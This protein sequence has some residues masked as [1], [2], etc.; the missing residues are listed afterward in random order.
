MICPLPRAREMS[1]SETRGRRDIA[2]QGGGDGLRRGDGG[3]GH[4]AAGG[5]LARTGG[6]PH[7]AASRGGTSTSATSNRTRQRRSVRGCRVAATRW[8]PAWLALSPDARQTLI[9]VLDNATKRPLYAQLWRAE[10]LH[11]VLTAV[12]YVFRQWGLP[13]ALYTD[14]VGWA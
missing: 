6:R 4:E 10:T 2:N 7:V 8:Q 1:A 9:T 13:Q 5:H 11:A 12:A 14:R 3:A